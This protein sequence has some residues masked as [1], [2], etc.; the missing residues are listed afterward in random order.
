MNLTALQAAF[1]S[2]KIPA[3]CNSFQTAAIDA[4]EHSIRGTRAAFM[5]MN[6]AVRLSR[7]LESTQQ[8]FIKAISES[9]APYGAAKET[10]EAL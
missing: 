1:A 8:A 2:R 5:G 4:F 3:L 6:P 7:A 10:K 9:R